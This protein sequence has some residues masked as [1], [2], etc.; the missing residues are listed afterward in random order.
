[1]SSG[2]RFAFRPF[3]QPEREGGAQPASHAQPSAPRQAP[4][5]SF[6]RQ[7][8]APRPKTSAEHVVEVKE[9][10]MSNEEDGD[11]IHWTSSSDQT[12]M[13]PPPVTGG[14]RS[15]FNVLGSHTTFSPAPSANTNS[16]RT[17]FGQHSNREPRIA[18]E[19]ETHTLATEDIER[20]RS[21]SIH[22][23]GTPAV[24]DT[25]ERGTPS[26]RSNKLQNMIAASLAENEDLHAEQERLTAD[27][28]AS[29]EDVSR[30][31]AEKTALAKRASE[32]KDA[33][34]RIF[35]SKSNSLSELQSSL[36]RLDTQSRKS[37]PLASETRD[38]LSLLQNLRATVKEGIDKMNG[39]FNEEGNLS[40]VAD[41]RAVLA[42]IQRERD[43]SLNACELARSR[44][45]ECTSQL[46]V[47]HER[48]HEL[49][50]HVAFNV[51]ALQQA[52][53][54]ATNAEA[55]LNEERVKNKQLHSENV[56]TLLAHAQAEDEIGRLNEK[57]TV[58]VA[59]LEKTCEAMKELDELRREN[60]E[61][62]AIQS[63][64][65]TRAERDKELQALKA[66]IESSLATSS[67]ERTHTSELKMEL[68]SRDAELAGLRTRVEDVSAQLSSTQAAE[69]RLK[70]DVQLAVER[71]TTARLVQER[72]ASEAAAKDEAV[73]RL[74]GALS[75]SRED[76]EAAR[77]EV[78]K[79][80]GYAE[81]TQMRVDEL[82]V[83]LKTARDEK[84]AV[85]TRLLGMD[86]VHAT[87]LDAAITKHTQEAITLCERVANLTHAL[88]EAKSELGAQKVEL[89]TA[90]ADAEAARSKA[91][92]ADARVG[93]IQ[94]RFDDQAATLK[95]LRDAQADLQERL[96]D[97]Q[98]RHAVALGKAE[99]Q[100][101]K[102]T[103]VLVERADKL[104]SALEERKAEVTRLAEEL[105]VARIDADDRVSTVREAAENQAADVQEKLL[106][107]SEARGHAL[108]TAEAAQAQLHKAQA[109]LA[110]VRH[111][112]GDVA[113]TLEVARAECAALRKAI[114]DLQAEKTVLVEQRR[115]MHV[116]YKSNDLGEEEKAFVGTLLEE[117]QASHEKRLAEKQNELRRR[118]NIVTTLETKV[119]DLEQ[120][121]A[122]SVKSEKNWKRKFET[123]QQ[124]VADNAAAAAS[125]SVQQVPPAPSPA[126]QSIIDIKRFAPPSLGVDSPSGLAN[127]LA[128]DPE[129]SAAH[130]LRL[131]DADPLNSPPSESATSKRPAAVAGPTRA[132]PKPK[133]PVVESTISPP[134]AFTA[135]ASRARPAR[136]LKSKPSD[137]N[138]PGPSGKAT[139]GALG[140]L[141]LDSSPPQGKKPTLG[142]RPRADFE[143]GSSQGDASGRPK[144][145]QRSAAKKVARASGEGK[146]HEN[147]QPGPS[148]RKRLR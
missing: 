50:S 18:L 140:A 90:R 138:K 58:I 82:L 32:I 19:R 71:E 145:R 146:K 46:T 132:R 84:D 111:E 92:Q 28:T 13:P 126:A 65:L 3:R 60:A 144:T 81:T 101:T 134:L 94:Q 40:K 87:A 119:K 31:V 41:A 141:D 98:K 20:N 108:H 47:A 79:M 118:A 97:E 21:G 26:S 63:S 49:E 121:F 59:E 24:E 117:C 129:V 116:R 39:L 83:E 93:T 137:A 64:D 4:K 75:S 143:E 76:A 139:F 23:F 74:E 35:A 36:Q 124:S 48:I 56:D 107:A 136:P 103:A 80:H 122:Q 8:G 30:L 147:A 38:A 85:Q 70:D 51:A 29:R 109:E 142:K 68:A 17:A 52:S 12:M 22:S 66:H 112:R 148:T 44:L 15:R 27:L 89:A 53:T 10:P 67:H 131:F 5:L 61:L 45:A 113:G 128:R 110:A 6:F 95:L 88:E 33:S 42:E 99:G 55:H 106:A 43:S 102:E 115:T 2:S 62:R 73:A 96:A 25:A 69:R 1:M 9:E 78:A 7:S 77:A 105:A 14:Q 104:S 123:L 120:S 11:V 54:N 16:M 130:G 135:A 37:F 133:K 100:Y 86:S 72:L 127:E 57:V 91:T 34:R 114:E 125:A